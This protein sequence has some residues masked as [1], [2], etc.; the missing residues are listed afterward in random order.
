MFFQ[1]MPAKQKAPGIT[2]GFFCQT[3]LELDHVGGLRSLGA[4]LNREFDLLAF[5]KI[6]ESITLDSGEVD[7]NVRAAIASDEAITL[8]TIEPFD[9]AGD[10]V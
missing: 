3:G 10:T 2:G 9:C 5:F 4:L 8:G 7:E 6:A 1:V